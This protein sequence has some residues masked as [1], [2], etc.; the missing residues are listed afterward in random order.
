MEEIAEKELV[1]EINDDQFEDEVV[2]SDLP[3]VVDCYA[4]WCG[5]CR[6]L[7]PILDELAEEYKGKI[8]VVKLDVDQSPKTSQEFG[9]MSIPT[10]LYFKD[11]KKVNATVGA[12]P[13]PMLKEHFEK[14][15]K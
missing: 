2:K 13:K 8:K 10:V 7:S 5:P 3:T 15:L 14:L 11:G 9:I 4:V 12:M 1:A 6:I